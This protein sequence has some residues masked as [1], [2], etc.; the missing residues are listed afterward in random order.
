M[1]KDYVFDLK[2]I[3]ILNISLYDE[4]QDKIKFCYDRIDRSVHY[5]LDEIREMPDN[6]CKRRLVEV[7]NLLRGGNYQ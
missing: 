2:D 1:K 5:I 7:L 6:E 4:I 3:V